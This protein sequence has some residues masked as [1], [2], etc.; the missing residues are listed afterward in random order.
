MTGAAK[1]NDLVAFTA[2]AIQHFGAVRWAQL[3]VDSVPCW[4][5][6]EHPIA[7][8]RRMG[9]TVET[10]K[11]GPPMPKSQRGEGP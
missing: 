11:P 10:F 5:Y 6:G 9:L 7:K 3:Q 4:Q 2:A 8:A 1:G